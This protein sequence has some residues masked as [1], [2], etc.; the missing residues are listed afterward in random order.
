MCKSNS[1]RSLTTSHLIRQIQSGVREN[2]D[3]P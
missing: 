1:S 2:L 3:S